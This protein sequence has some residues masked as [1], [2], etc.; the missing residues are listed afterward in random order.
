MITQP[1][2][3]MMDHLLSKGNPC[4]SF[5][6]A[7]PNSDLTVKIAKDRLDAELRIEIRKFVEVNQRIVTLLPLI[8]VSTF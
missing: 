7:H 1:M 6:F 3:L 8:C 2:Y 4:G 5:S